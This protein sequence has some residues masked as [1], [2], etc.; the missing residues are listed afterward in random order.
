MQHLAASFSNL[1]ASAAITSPVAVAAGSVA[2]FKPSLLNKFG[3][4][5]PGLS[6]SEPLAKPSKPK[7]VA[8][9][10]AVL[11]TLAS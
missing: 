6:N 8:F 4:S 3:I 11:V 1:L 10:K 5:P 2:A 7:S 9:C